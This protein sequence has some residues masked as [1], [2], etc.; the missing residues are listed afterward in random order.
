VQFIH[1][2]PLQER[3]H[4]CPHCDYFPHHN[5]SPVSNDLSSVEHTSSLSSSVDVS[6]GL[7]IL[8]S[9]CVSPDFLSRFHLACTMASA[10]LTLSLHFFCLCRYSSLTYSLG[11]LVCLQ[12][13]VFLPLSLS[14]G[15]N[16]SLPSNVVS[17]EPSPVLCEVVCLYHPTSSPIAPLLP[18][19]LSSRCRPVHS[20]LFLSALHSEACV[21]FRPIT[22]LLSSHALVSSLPSSL[23]SP[24]PY[25]LHFVSVPSPSPR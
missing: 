18:S 7:T 6:S 16:S 15:V 24:I 20:Y 11:L 21:F 22:F 9:P 17:C 5:P 1:P 23:C 19:L 14:L 4:L 2:F 10:S 13:I 12:D 25:E 3:A 8:P